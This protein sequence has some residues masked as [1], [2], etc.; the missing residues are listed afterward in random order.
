MSRRVAAVAQ[1]DAVAD[2]VAAAVCT[3]DEVMDVE[4]RAGRGR[5]A[6]AAAVLVTVKDDSAHGLPRRLLLRTSSSTHPCSKASMRHASVAGPYG[7]RG[8]SRRRGD[9]R[10]SVCRH[11]AAARHRSTRQA[12]SCPPD[13]FAVGPSAAL[14]WEGVARPDG[15]R[16]VTCERL[17]SG[18]DSIASTSCFSL[19]RDG[20]T[21]SL[22]T[23]RMRM[24]S[25]R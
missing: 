1:R 11:D 12:L 18:H 14:G 15:G 16:L 24:R 13:R 3:A 2:L 8:R 6:I 20:G 4:L 10:V 7:V 25:R 5:T 21:Q 17:G 23:W 19:R 22:S 9:A